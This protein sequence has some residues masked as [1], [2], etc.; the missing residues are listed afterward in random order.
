MHEPCV[1]FYGGSPSLLGWQGHVSS[2]HIGCWSMQA[3]CH[4]ALFQA[5][6]CRSSVVH[7]GWVYQLCLGSQSTVTDHDSRN[8]LHVDLEDWSSFGC[9]TCC[10]VSFLS[11]VVSTQLMVS[12]VHPL[13]GFATYPI[14]P[15]S[16][17]GTMFSLYPFSTAAIMLQALSSTVYMPS[18][19]CRVHLIAI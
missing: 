18:L 5:D 16:H 3:S 14:W 8:F 12:T 10:L 1:P 2:K 9:R 6:R 15:H 13:V 4:P 7:A 19:Q 17:A 11:V